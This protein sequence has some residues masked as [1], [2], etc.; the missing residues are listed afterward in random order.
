MNHD[1]DL[2]DPSRWKSQRLRRGSRVSN[3]WWRDDNSSLRRE[4]RGERCSVYP[5]R[6]QQPVCVC[7]LT[8]CPVIIIINIIYLQ[9]ALQ[10][11]NSPISSQQ[12]ALKKHPMTNFNPRS[13]CKEKLKTIWIWKWI[14]RL[15]FCSCY[16]HNTAPS[17][18]RGGVVIFYL[19]FIEDCVA[20]I[21]QKVF[22]TCG[23]IAR[24]L[25]QRLWMSCPGSALE[26]NS[27]GKNTKSN[28]WVLRVFT[29]HKEKSSPHIYDDK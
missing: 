24:C 11:A 18:E 1:P 25:Y 19:G 8:N 23:S 5:K 2:H 27:R 20:S 15:V 4:R 3:V 22:V 13:C 17:S 29:E 21:F 9:S 14:V 6:P 7:V 26:L 16:L 28:S 10:I 12:V